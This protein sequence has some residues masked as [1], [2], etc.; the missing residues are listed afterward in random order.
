MVFFLYAEN[1]SIHFR[2]LQTSILTLFRIDT[3]E[4]W[5]DVIYNN[6]CGSG[7]YVYGTEELDKWSPTS[8][9]SP[10]G[11]S[12]FCEFCAHQ[13]YNFAKSSDRSNYEQQG[14]IKCL[15]KN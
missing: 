6:M 10:P 15:N 14:R 13:N 4:D 12:F 5:T 3:L 9:A 11:A 1:D 8:S 7:N 2:N